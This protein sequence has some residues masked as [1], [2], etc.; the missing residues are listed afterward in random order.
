MV[1][2]FILILY[3]RPFVIS[4]I[5]N[6][7]VIDFNVENEDTDRNENENKNHYLNTDKW[8]MKH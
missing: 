5:A 4:M 8:K 2:K 1:L 3:P 7:K 6:K